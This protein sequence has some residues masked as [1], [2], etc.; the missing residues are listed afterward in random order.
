[1]TYI[2]SLYF[3]ERMSLFSAFFVQNGGLYV[4]VWLTVTALIG[5]VLTLVFI[6][7]FRFFH[8]FFI[9][10]IVKFNKLTLFTSFSLQV[11][12]KIPGRIQ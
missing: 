2:L 5:I 6:L 3:L 8:V 7:D 11:L 12:I 10:S 9:L 1:M 4:V